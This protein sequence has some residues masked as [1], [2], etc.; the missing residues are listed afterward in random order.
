[1]LQTYTYDPDDAVIGCLPA[2]T[3]L[4]D[5]RVNYAH[6][7]D[8]TTEPHLL[9]HTDPRPISILLTFGRGKIR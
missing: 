9:C 4:Q 8:A 7:I 5:Q 6:P 2:S 1:M 3:D